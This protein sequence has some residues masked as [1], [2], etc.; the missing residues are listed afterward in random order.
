MR[1]DVR[2]PR[3]DR[4]ASNRGLTTLLAA[5]V[6]FVATAAR[7]AVPGGIAVVEVPPDARA[8]FDGKPVFTLTAPKSVAIVGIGLDTKVGRY[9]LVVDSPSQG[10]AEVP[11]DV[12]AKSYP[13][14]RLTLPPDKVNPPPEA[15]PRIERETRLTQE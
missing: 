8:T 5:L 2:R 11:V 15:M 13:E 4:C 10:R 3:A 6:A 9:V 14:Q 12:A 7:G 1:I